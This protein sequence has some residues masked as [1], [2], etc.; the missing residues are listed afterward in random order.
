MFTL[1]FTSQGIFII[2]LL[3]R[4]ILFIKVESQSVVLRLKHWCMQRV[5][6]KYLRRKIFFKNK[7]FENIQQ[8]G[9]ILNA[10]TMTP[11]IL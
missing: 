5:F 2:K 7:Y 4:K 11:K 10:S 6:G 1:V 9:K 8:P 3:T